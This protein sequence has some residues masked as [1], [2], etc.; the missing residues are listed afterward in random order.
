MSDDERKENIFSIEDEVKKQQEDLEDFDDEGKKFLIFENGNKVSAFWSK[1]LEVQSNC[2]S[3]P[4]VF[5][6][7]EECQLRKWL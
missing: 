6:D 2:G 3:I 1:T 5:W 7:I 4:F